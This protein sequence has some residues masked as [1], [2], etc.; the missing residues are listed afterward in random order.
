MDRNLADVI[1]IDLA[2][3]QFSG[4][5]QAIQRSNM[6]R[7]LIPLNIFG[8]DY[9]LH[10]LFKRVRIEVCLKQKSACTKCV[11]IFTYIFMA[12]KGKPTLILCWLLDQFAMGKQT[13]LPMKGVAT[14]N[15]IA[16]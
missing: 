10:R 15:N 7:F 4:K 5:L 1:T 12:I 11:Y 16:E 9:V 8:F 6:E 3:L 13:L 2:L 14:K